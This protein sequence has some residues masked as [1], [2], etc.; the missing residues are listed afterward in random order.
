MKAIKTHSTYTGYFLKGSDTY[1]GY[2]AKGSD[3]VIFLYSIS[4]ENVH[5]YFL[6]GY[7]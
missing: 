7:P 4:I 6:L 1:T 2:F 5:V 3:T